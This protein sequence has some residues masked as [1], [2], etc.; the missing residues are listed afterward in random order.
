MS[1]DGSTTFVW[2]G[3]ERRFRLGI[4][5][6]LALQERRNSGPQEILNRFRFST[7]RIED[8]Q[9]IIRLG[10]IGAMMVDGA[11][12]AAVGKKARELVDANVRAGNITD[13]A[14]P[15]LKILLAGLQ[16]DPDDPVGK[17]QATTDAP[18]ASTASP[19]PPSSEAVR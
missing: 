13:N 7:W 10:L 17:E 4:G 1:A 12:A 14:A 9:E 18:E 5:E 3:D 6:L 2:G 15:A 19:P 8:I 11:D 16:G